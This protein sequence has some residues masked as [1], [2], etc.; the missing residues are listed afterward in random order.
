M[1]Y[2]HRDP[3]FTCEPQAKILRTQ[4]LDIW[5]TED[6]NNDDLS[7]TTALRKWRDEVLTRLINKRPC[8]IRIPQRL[9]S[10]CKLT[11]QKVWVERDGSVW[12]Q[13]PREPVGRRQLVAAIQ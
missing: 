6:L 10:V 11:S 4:M 2:A 7:Y 3:Y 13:S 5:I 8:T 12:N 9:M 1:C